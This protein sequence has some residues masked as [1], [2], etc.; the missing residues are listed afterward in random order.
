MTELSESRKRIDEIDKQFVHLF[1]ERMAVVNDIAEYKINSGMPILDSK[2]EEEKLDAVSS[3]AHTDFNS[4]AVRDLF[5]QLL[6]ISREYQ[7]NLI[8]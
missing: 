2:R 6:S 3:L 4:A 8:K 1:E 7:K 5:K